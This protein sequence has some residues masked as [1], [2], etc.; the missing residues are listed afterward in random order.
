MNIISVKI[1]LILIALLE[2]RRRKVK[3]WAGCRVLLLY[4]LGSYVLQMNLEV[5]TSC[6]TVFTFT[7]ERGKN[8]IEAEHSQGHYVTYYKRV[9]LSVESDTADVRHSRYI[10]RKAE[11]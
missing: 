1:V 3:S 11:A 2:E 9:W 10:V 5:A 7:T 4:S 8:D 6:V